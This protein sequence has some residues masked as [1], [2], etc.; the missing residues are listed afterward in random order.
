MRN[1]LGFAG[2]RD[3]SRRISDPAAL[4]RYQDVVVRLVRTCLL[5]RRGAPSRGGAARGVPCLLELLEN[6]DVGALTTGG[7]EAGE[8]EEETEE[9]GA[10]ELKKEA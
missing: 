2:A 10:A 3:P 8:E 7:G 5:Q 6:L 9:E 4:G 1:A